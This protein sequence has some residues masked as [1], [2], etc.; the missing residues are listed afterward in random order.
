MYEYLFIHLS[1]Y[2]TNYSRVG[3]SVRSYSIVS[4]PT[5]LPLQLPY[6]N[7]PL[8]LTMLHICLNHTML[9]RPYV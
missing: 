4:S 6:L 8:K 9:D 1:T 3:P 7:H 5:R 2:P